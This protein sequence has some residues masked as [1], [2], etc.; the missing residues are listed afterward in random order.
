[1]NK[2]LYAIMLA[3]SS[4]V[5]VSCGDDDN[6]PKTG[7]ATLPLVID[8]QKESTSFDFSN[9]ASFRPLVV[10][11]M[12]FWSYKGNLESLKNVVKDN[13][14]RAENEDV[15]FTYVNGTYIS[16]ETNDEAN[17]SGTIHLSD[18]HKIVANINKFGDR[19]SKITIV[20]LDEGSSLRASLFVNNKL[21]MNYKN[22]EVTDG[23][24]KI[25][26]DVNHNKVTQLQIA[27]GSAAIKRIIFE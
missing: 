4:L 25:V 10:K 12:R 11:L 21:Y 2:L 8:F 15:A 6:E 13:Y 1:M 26:F 7:P 19:L 23:E 22:E 20:G 18:T 9:Q 14:L 24:I 16:H 3:L 17:W 27:G 5:L